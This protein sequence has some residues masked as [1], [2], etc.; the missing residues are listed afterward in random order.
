MV[1][2]AQSHRAPTQRFIDRFAAI[3]TPAVVAIAALV[4]LVP[5]L[6]FDQPFLDSP[7]GTHGWLYRGLAILVIACPC[8]LVIS[9]PVTILSAIS[10][11]ARRGVLFKGGVY[12]ETLAEVRRIAFDKTGTLTRGKPVL[13]RCRAIDCTGEENCSACEEVLA[14]AAALEQRSLHPLAGAVVE[15]A[16][17]R[18]LLERYPPA[19]GVE[20]VNSS[21][22]R[23]QVAGQTAVIGR[24]LHFDEFHPHSAELCAQ[25][26]AAEL[27]GE[28]TMVVSYAGQVRGFLAAADEI[29]PESRGVIAALR[30]LGLNSVMLTGD[31]AETAQRVGARLGIHD[32]RAGLLPEGKVGA[33][34]SLM[35]EDGGMAMVGDGI[36]DAPAL[37]QSS[38]GIAVAGPG[39]AS[40]META[41]VVLL[42]GNLEKLPFA[43]RIARLARKLIYQ[44]IAFSIATKLIFICLALSG[45]ATMWMAVLADMGVSLLVTLNALRPFNLKD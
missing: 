8:A 42:A 22:L 20:M 41:D 31:N 27:N 18:G 38:L 12:L 21:A 24:H 5:P 4:A 34:Q 15:A 10:S 6:L 14:I 16:R 40:A 33:V 45:L 26:E 37:A 32:L 35:A 25:I 29:R 11:A 1:T 36:N 43:V 28:T 13:T 9:A 2:E 3:Y 7:D 23:G 30:A 39:N 17:A 44:N 19:D